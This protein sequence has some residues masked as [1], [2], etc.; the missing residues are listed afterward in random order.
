MIP[1]DDHPVNKA[2]D[3]LHTEGKPAVPAGDP[4]GTAGTPAKLARAKRRTLGSRGEGAAAAVRVR[5]LG[6]VL[7]AVALV[8]A[9]G[10]LVAAT[11]LAPQGPAGSRPIA[12]P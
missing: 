6:G 10:G 8:A 4:A 1:N 2:P 12:A 9:G 11:A 3:A 7:A 5:R